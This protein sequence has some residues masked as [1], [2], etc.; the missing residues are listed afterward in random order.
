EDTSMTRLEDHFAMLLIAGAPPDLVLPALRSRLSDV[1]ASYGLH[2]SADEIET[3]EETV[4]GK[5]RAYVVSVSG[6]DQMGIIYHVS[7]ALGA[8]AINIRTLA[9]K[10]LVR[11]DGK[12]LF[13]MTLE[14]EVPDELSEG[15]L[16]QDLQRV[17]REQNLDVH[18]EPLEEYTL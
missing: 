13:L 14:V 3:A 4:R 6:F 15:R 17:G 1:A 18:A 2:L 11:E 9:S 10:R 7:R 12:P 8:M 16:Q 5:G